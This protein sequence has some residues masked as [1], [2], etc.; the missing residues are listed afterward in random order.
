MARPGRGR[1]VVWGWERCD[2]AG[3]ARLGTRDQGRAIAAVMPKLEISRDHESSISFRFWLQPMQT[4]RSNVLHTF[5]TKP[6]LIPLAATVGLTCAGYAALVLHSIAYVRPA[7][8]G[9][10]DRAAGRD[11]R[12]SGQEHQGAHIQS[13]SRGSCAGSAPPPKADRVAASSGR[14]VRACRAP[15]RRSWTGRPRRRSTR[16]SVLRSSPSSAGSRSV[17]A[18]S[19]RTTRPS[20]RRHPVPSPCTLHLYPA[21]P[22]TPAMYVVSIPAPRRQSATATPR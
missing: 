9:P 5:K 3:L 17:V 1:G 13:V 2:R 20:T 12:A 16:R 14:R 7:F 21:V 4:I 11:Q 18:R 10:A 22:C 15:R 6:S 8:L 19:P